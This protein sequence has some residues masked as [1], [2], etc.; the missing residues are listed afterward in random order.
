MCFLARRTDGGACPSLR[1]VL[2]AIHCHR[3]TGAIVDS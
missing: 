3:Y 1:C 2:P